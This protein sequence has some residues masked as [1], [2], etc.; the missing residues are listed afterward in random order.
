MKK[1]LVILLVLFL[2]GCS[3]NEKSIQISLNETLSTFDNAIKKSNKYHNDYI[4]YYIDPSIGRVESNEISHIFNYDGTNFIM[5]INVANIINNQWY[6]KDITNTKLN[7][8]I[9]KY[10]GTYFDKDLDVH[11]YEINVYPIENKYLLRFDTYY[12]HFYSYCDEL[13]IDELSL[14]MLNIAKSVILN[15]NKIISNFSIKETITY[16][17]SYLDLF[18]NKVPESGSIEELLKDDDVLQGLENNDEGR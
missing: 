13:I 11:S 6:G 8:S 15:K 1:F 7:N 14:E 16:Q 12:I 2:V 17:P 9:A 3:S 10:E 5:N 18:D 4:S